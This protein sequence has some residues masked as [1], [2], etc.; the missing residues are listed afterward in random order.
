MHI[1]QLKDISLS[2][3][4]IYKANSLFDNLS[5]AVGDKDRV[6]LVG[7][8]GAGKST[9]LK[10]MLGI[11]QPERG[12][13]TRARS[14]TVGYLPQHAE[15]PAGSTLFEQASALPPQ[16]ATVDA[17]LNAIETRLSD[18]AV[19]NDSD[20]LTA[21][22]SVQEKL[23]E[24]YERLGGAG[25]VGKV[26]EILSHLGFTPDDYDLPTDGLSGGQKK[27]TLLTRLVAEQPDLLLLDE[28]D[29]HLDLAAKRRLELLLKHYTGAFVIVSHDRYLL[30]E[31]VNQIAELENGALTIYPGN[32][33]Q[34]ATE[35]ELRRL[36]QQQLYI[37]Q[38]KR[39][40]Q[41]EEAIKRFELTAAADVD[42]GRA[43]RQARARHKMLERME[44]N[45]E[46]V[47]RVRERK[48]ME[49]ALAGGR[50]STKALELHKLAM[51]F[52]DNLIFTD[53][54]L[55]VQ[56]GE[57]VGLIGGNGAGKSVLLK[58]VMGDYAPLSGS[59]KVGA[60]SRVGYYAQEHQTLAAWGDSTPIDFVRAV[61]PT[62]ENVAV[63]LLL[64]MLFTYDQTRQPIRTLS[65]G[66]R[67]R[68]QLTALML[69]KP[70]LLLLDEP[71]NNLDI[72]ASEAL[73]SALDEFV[74]AALI[75][76]HDCYFLDRVVDRVVELHPGGL[77]S[78][79]GSYTDYLDHQAK[80]AARRAGGVD[81]KKRS[82][83]K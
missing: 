35:R 30:D 36:R 62:P 12:A 75:I 10:L 51:A 72:P 55:L 76:S 79:P 46:L 48:Q 64:K 13:I 6:G 58:M 44:A 67:S 29:N 82:A 47:E 31:V 11:L 4:G 8:N 26:R 63:G 77:V 59:I 57:R 70:N 73:E 23:L 71:T 1:F 38:Q 50:G 39:V 45:G 18:P 28:P 68:L 69:Q 25:H 74:G 7:P 80:Q 56:H 60:S 16:L 34:Y 78:Y 53:V 5:W 19:Y 54:E 2:N 49:L 15:L 24:T 83:V 37:A 22:L 17:E 32:Y 52:D 14:V 9:L 81:P 27:L 65:G 40:S 66:E 61:A 42:D 43:A 3:T 33:S 21:T 20:R 41:I